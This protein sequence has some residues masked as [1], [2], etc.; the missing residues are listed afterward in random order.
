[1]IIYEY[2]YI[3]ISICLRLRLSAYSTAYVW[4]CNTV[5]RKVLLT[6]PSHCV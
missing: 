2:I 6:S 3:Y 5:L 1:M 4:K